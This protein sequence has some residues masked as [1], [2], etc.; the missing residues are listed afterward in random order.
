MDLAKQRF[1]LKRLGLVGWFLSSG[2]LLRS[3]AADWPQ[4]RGPHHDGSSSEELRT[5]WKSNPPKVVWR[6]TLGPAWSSMTVSNGRVFTQV[7]RTVDGVDREHCVALDANTGEQKWATNLDLADYPDAGTGSDDGPRSTP[8]V[9]GDRVYVLTSYLKLYC[10]SADTG[11]VVWM[12]DFLAEFP[13]TQVISWQNASSPLVIGDLIFLN[14]N[15]R[16]QC[17]MA[18]RK[19]DGETI[20]S[21]QDERMTHATPTYATLGGIPQVVFLTGKGLLGVLPET[22]AV[23]WRHAFTPS[24]TSTAAT[25]I[26]AGDYI[27]A[28]CAYALGAWTANVTKPASVFVVSKPD[29]KRGSA[30]QNHWATPVAHDGFL[31]GIVENSFRSLSCFSLAGRT[32]RWLT[33]SVG[34][35]NPG[36]GSLIKVGGKL[37]I[38]TESG[39]LVLAEPNPEAYTEIASFQAVQGKCWN[40]PAY[41]NGRIYARS[42]KQLVVLDVAPAVVPLPSFSLHTQLMPDSGTLR[43]EIRSTEAGVPLQD[44]AAARLQLQGTSSLD[45]PLGWT[46]MDGSF[47]AVGG[48]L[49]RDITLG[50]GAAHHFLR[51]RERTSISP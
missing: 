35:V 44:S 20:W 8:S 45:D 1:L 42:S 17:L 9:D 18:V 23:Q 5:D 50:T 22:G 31:Y 30:Y 51:V 27:Y 4:Y 48:V 19:T 13:G 25:P 40:H 47:V 12:R 2:L 7:N 38:L 24:T 32:N 37:L 49:R 28:S 21:G 10:L 6:K 3:A 36:F 11:S 15:V 26:V 41:S 16:R 43:I 29:Y 33:Q 14:S 34:G 46:P 39:R